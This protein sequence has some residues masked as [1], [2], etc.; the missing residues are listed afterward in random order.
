MTTITTTS[1]TITKTSAPATTTRTAVVAA[2]PITTLLS[3]SH[4]Q[5]GNGS[6]PRSSPG[7]STGILDRFDSG[8]LPTTPAEPGHALGSVTPDV[9]PSHQHHCNV[10]WTSGGVSTSN[11]V[12]VGRRQWRMASVWKTFTD[13]HIKLEAIVSIQYYYFRCCA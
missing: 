4:S 12:H 6:P 2:S 3:L 10:D 1:A 13:L 9:L 5:S 7:S 11:T 8:D